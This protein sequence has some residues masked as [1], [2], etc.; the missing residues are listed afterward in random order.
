MPGVPRFPDQLTTGPLLVR[1]RTR[2]LASVVLGTT[3]VEWYL[4]HHARPGCDPS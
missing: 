2:N 3:A 4:R 1:R